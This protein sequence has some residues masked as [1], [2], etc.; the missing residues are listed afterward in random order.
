MAPRLLF[1][2]RESIETPKLWA[3]EYNESPALAVYCTFCA[4]S[5]FTSEL[6]WV[7]TCE[8]LC[9]TAE[10]EL[11]AGCWAT[12]LLELVAAACE[13]AGVVTEE[14]VAVVAAELFWA[15]ETA[16]ELLE[17]EVA[18]AWL[19]WLSVAGVVTVALSC[20]CCWVL[21]VLVA[22]AEV[23]LITCPG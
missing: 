15:V 9:W 16:C 12:E 21:G 7:V 13:A 23:N 10:L 14:L 11:A 8:E 20:T 3:I 4:L 22:A 1:E 6:L 18:C 17:A 2:R 19:L 5:S